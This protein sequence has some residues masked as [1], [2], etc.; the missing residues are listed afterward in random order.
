M[1]DEVA[2]LRALL[3]VMEVVARHPDI[4][5][6]D[7][8]E[9]LTDA[10][11]EHVELERIAVLIPDG[12]G[13]RRL[14]ALSHG[15]LPFPFGVRLPARL[16][17]A[18]VVV[19]GEEPYFCDDTREGQ[20]GEQMA[21]QLGV[22]SFVVLPI[23][24]SGLIRGADGT[25]RPSPRRV[26]AMLV[27][28]FTEVGASRK[29]PLDIWQGVAD[30]I[31]AA[32]E[33]GYSGAREHRL[34]RILES[35]GDA[36]LA[37]D[38]EGRVTDANASAALLTGRQRSELVGM[39]VGDLLDPLPLPDERGGS[40]LGGARLELTVR[41]PGG[42][43]KVTV[44]AT[45]TA[46]DDDAEVAAH[47]LLRDLSEVV[48]A[49]RE[50]AAGLQRIRALEEE[51]RTLLDNAPLI[52]FRLDPAS[53]E[54]LYLNRK[55]EHLLGVP[56]YEALATP[57]FLRAIHAD[58]EGASA[59]D[60]AIAS[61]RRGVTG[62]PYEA[63]LR[64]RD[65][66]GIAARGTVYPL[67]DADGD[68]IAIEGV[69][70]DVSAEQAARTRLVQSDRLSTIGS[71]AAGVA[72]EINNPA[73]FILLGLDLLERLLNGPGVQMT[74]TASA[75]AQD[76]VRELRDSIRRIVDI[77]RDL[78]LFASPPAPDGVRKT[79][80]D[81]NRTVLS[82]VSLTR[83]QLLER[84]EIALDLGDVPPVMMD[85]GRLG[86][87][88]VNLLVNAAQAIPRNQQNNKA[89]R[90]ST[91][92]DGQTIEIEVEDTGTGI[93]DEHLG[94]IWQPFFTTK[95]A[96]LGI[97]LGLAISREIVERAGGTISAL[98]PAPGTDP[99]VGSRF[100]VLL[101]AAGSTEPVAPR[102]SPLLPGSLP[103]VRVLVVE[104]EPALCRAL[105][106]EIARHHDVT[107]APNAEVALARLAEGP[108]DAVLCD[109]R[110]PGMNG[111]ALYEKILE[112]NEPQ[113]RRFIFMTGVGFGAEV[114]RF[115]TASGRPVLEKPFVGDAVVSAINRLVKKSRLATA[116]P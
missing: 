113:A 45:V 79:I 2:R 1:S 82:A 60:D 88:V 34:A 25:V 14:Y 35:S 116:T 59:F 48:A 15:G 40:T 87:V 108:F 77:T 110:M 98:S 103:R 75:S 96:E 65:G 111:E 3:S 32:V 86:Q 33:R 53:G 46:V 104:D 6:A 112:E 52:I 115:L 81:V 94:R 21:A 50:A 107:V 97:G 74:G 71:L 101:P 70:A 22:L 99:P 109:L 43:R 12:P 69:L 55:A 47:A 26:V 23:R 30:A 114:E 85:G 41:A 13:Y 4:L 20:L 84:A 16:P 72:H 67:L 28:T 31:G 38:R 39:A 90:V 62:S 68:V 37:W 57:G 24:S 78:R 66:E 61:A 8:F 44:A 100:T 19:R 105:A 89:V 36:M 93:S 11:V 76:T 102:S 64:R 91:R 106:D 51:H 73:A 18:D 92:S 54:L 29:A 95:T 17:L 80:A 63:R 49:E 5:R 56:T 27:V 42:D 83:G 7:V 58:D 10:L 9:E